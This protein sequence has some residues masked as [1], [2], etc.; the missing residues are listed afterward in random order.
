MSPL[1]NDIPCLPHVQSA[2]P[3]IVSYYLFAH[4]SGMLDGE[5]LRAGFVYIY[6]CSWHREEGSRQQDREGSKLLFKR[7]IWSQADMN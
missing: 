1:L 6:I 3:F 7:G 4:L 2:T 5:P